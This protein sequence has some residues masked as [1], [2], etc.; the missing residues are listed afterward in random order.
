[1]DTDTP[2]ATSEVIVQNS[3]SS[4]PEHMELLKQIQQGQAQQNSELIT[5]LEALTQALTANVAS[6]KRKTSQPENSGPKR[7]IAKSDDERNNESHENSSNSRKDVTRANAESD[8]EISD[9]DNLDVS[10]DNISMPDQDQ[11]DKDIEALMEGDSGVSGEDKKGPS[12]SLLDKIAED[13]SMADD[14]GEDINP[15]L[16]K[17]IDGLWANKLGEDKLKDKLK[18]YPT[19][20]NCSNMIVPKCNHEIWTNSLTSNLRF[21]DLNL[22]KTQCQISKAATAV[23]LVCNQLIAQKTSEDKKLDTNKLISLTTD[24]LALLGNSVQELSQRRREAIKAKLPQRLQHLASNVPAKSTL[25]FGDDINKRIQAISST[26]RALTSGN[27]SAF[28]RADYQSLNSKS[29]S[30][31]YSKNRQYPQR[32]SAS[33]RRGFRQ[34]RRGRSFRS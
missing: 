10:D 28:K 1:M 22:Q 29:Q 14:K 4:D 26:N 19:P 12:D 18:K 24:A 31:Q 30:W 27:A 3:N 9:H 32:G 17:I 16:A 5:R 13:L 25:L 11:I 8:D 34:S 33:G 23:I 7:K 2:D 6:Q 15:Q 21:N 20:A